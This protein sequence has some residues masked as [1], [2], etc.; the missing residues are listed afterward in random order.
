[1]T[2][3]RPSA[4]QKAA[5]SLFTAGNGER[6]VSTNILIRLLWLKATFYV[7]PLERQL[8]DERQINSDLLG[9]LAALSAFRRLTK[10]KTRHVV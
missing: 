3:Y 5:A 1:L 7:R 6:C 10:R 9:R 2:D 8:Q 4:R